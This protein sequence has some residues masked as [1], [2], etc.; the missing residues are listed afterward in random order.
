MEFIIKWTVHWSV[1]YKN[2]N[3]LTESTYIPFE[4]IDLIR[5]LIFSNNDILLPMENTSTSIN[6]DRNYLLADNR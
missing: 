6:N 2:K 5:C 4:M 1:V 3:Q